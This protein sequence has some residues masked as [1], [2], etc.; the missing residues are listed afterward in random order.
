MQSVDTSVRARKSCDA[1]WTP[2]G[3]LALLRQAYGDAQIGA[4]DEKLKGFKLLA[5]DSSIEQN[6]EV[7][8]LTYGEMLPQ[9]VS[10]ALGPER[11]VPS[12]QARILLDLGMGTGKFAMQAFLEASCLEHVMGVELTNAR[13]RIAA[14]ALKKLAA[15]NPGRFGCQVHRDPETGEEKSVRLVENWRSVEFRLGDIFQ[16]ENE[17]INK[18]DA[19]IMA[20]AF[21]TEMHTRVQQLLKGAKQ[22][23]RFLTYEDHGLE[24]SRTWDAPAPRAF[25]RLACNTTHDHY[26]VSWVPKP[27]HRFHLHEVGAF[28][29]RSAVRK[30]SSGTVQSHAESKMCHEDPETK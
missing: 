10:K 23:C 21:P 12:T 6:E 4:L 9:G 11:L 18:A 3:V 17:L 14:K 24:V 28:Q 29:N 20:V 1:A 7:F 27:G 30:R 19:I 13:F 25:N 2:P 16:V 5:A 15:R 26:P 8:D 22:G